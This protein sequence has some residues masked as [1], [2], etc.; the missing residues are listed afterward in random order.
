MDW[1]IGWEMTFETLRVVAMVIKGKGHKYATELRNFKP[2]ELAGAVIFSLDI[3]PMIK[4]KHKQMFI[5][6]LRSNRFFYQNPVSW[7]LIP[8]H[9]YFATLIQFVLIQMPWIQQFWEISTVWSFD[10]IKSVTW[11]CWMTPKL[12]LINVKPHWISKSPGPSVKAPWVGVK[13]VKK[14]SSENLKSHQYSWNF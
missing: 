11:K 3:L 8:Q 13:A 4:L 9:F 10:N 7:L 2:E 12:K 6:C 1:V 5:F 14:Y